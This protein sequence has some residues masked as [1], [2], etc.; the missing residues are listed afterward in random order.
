MSKKYSGI[1]FLLS[2]GKYSGF[3]ASKTDASIHLCF[4]WVG[5][6]VFFFDMEIMLYD[7]ATEVSDEKNS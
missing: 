6:S 3:Y 4:G 7:L 1:S 5:L 2:I